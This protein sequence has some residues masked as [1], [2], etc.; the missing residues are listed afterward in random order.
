MSS[1]PD[2]NIPFSILIL[3]NTQWPPITPGKNLTCGRLPNLFVKRD[4]FVVVRPGCFAVS[5]HF[6]G[7]GN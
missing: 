1:T 2:L 4:D 5:F 6:L 3:G 7:P